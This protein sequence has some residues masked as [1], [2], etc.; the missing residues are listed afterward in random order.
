MLRTLPLCGLLLAAV[1]TQAQTLDIWTGP[2]SGGEWNTLASWSTGNPPLDS[3]TNALIGPGTNVTYSLPMG[4]TS[5]GILTNK[6]VL[7]I[8]T[9]GFNNTGIVMLNPAGTGKI[10]IGT[11]GV[12]NVSG[13]LAFCS[14]SV[15]AVSNGANLNVSGSL[16]VGCS[17]TGG[18]GTGSAGSFGILTNYGNLIAPVTSLNPGNGSVSSPCL[19][20]INGGTNNLGTV[21]IKRMGASGYGTLGAEGLVINGGVVTMTNLNAGANGAAN[22]YLTALITGGVVTNQGSVFISQGT[23]AR[24]SRVL[25]TGGLFVVPDPG[26]INPNPSASAAGTLN[27]YAVLGGTNIVGG[28]Y[29]GNSN[30]TSVGTIYFTNGAAIYVGSQGIYSNGAVTVNA[31]LNAGALFGATAPWTNAVAMKLIGGLFTFQTA[32]LDN[33]VNNIT[34]AGALS[35]AGGLN[36][37]GGGTLTLAAT[38]TYTGNTYVLGGTLAIGAT[39]GLGSPKITLA[40]GT[41]L[42]VIATGGFPLGGSQTLTGSGTVNGPVSPA[43]GATIAPGSNNVTGTLTFQGSL[44]ETGGVNNLFYLSSNP[45]GANNDFISAPGGLAL[46]GTNTITIVGSLANSGIYPLIDYGSSLTGDLTNLVV[47][48]PTGV[49]SNSATAHTIYF[50]PQ[51]SIRNATN[52]VWV[53]NPSANNWDTLGS[54]NWLNQGALDFFVAGDSVLFND[55]GTTNSIVNLPGTVTPGTI[56]INTSSNY[57]FTGSGA[58]SGTGS[59]TVSNGTL[60]VLTTNTYTGPTTFAGGVLATPILADSGAASGIGAASSDPASLIFNG[61]TFN[62]FGAS[63]GTDHGFTLTNLGGTIDVTNGTTLTLNG[64]LTGNGSLTK[65]DNGSLTLSAG[66]SYSGNTL[67]TAGTLTLSNVT[68]AGSGAIILNGGSLVLGGAIKPANTILVTNNS[69]ISGGNTGGFTG[70]K[71]VGGSSNLLLNVTT[72]VLDLTGDMSTYSGVITFANGGGAGVRFNGSI[73]SPLATW[74]L[75]SGTMD[76]MIRTG[77]TSNNIGAL[78]GGNNTTLSGR[79][80]SNNNG[81]T[82]YYIGANGLSTTFDGIVQ[83]GS[84]GTS[85][86]TAINKVGSGTLALSGVSTHTGTT[87]IGSGILALVY[88]P[89]NSSDGSIN[90]SATIN[91]VSGAV[92]D[93]SGRSDATFP[94]GSS[95][96]QLLEGRGTI[97]GSLNVGGSGMVS[98]GGGTGGSTGI[99]T[100]TNAITLNGTAWMKLNRT[101]GTTSDRLAAST[102]TYGGTLVITNIGSPLQVG[103]TFTLFSGSSLNTGSFGT[104]V[105]PNYYGIDTSSLTVNGTITVTNAFRPAISTV[106]FS[107]L[108]SGTITLTLT[109]GVASGAVNILTSTNLS[110]GWTTNT[111]TTFD[112]NGNLNSYSLTVSNDLPQLF[113]ELQVY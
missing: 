56:T 87:T 74:D 36:L 64:I 34:L 23:S 25:Q 31:A 37:T 49:L 26:V 28:F 44:T 33:T 102:I 111:A 60:T 20:Q 100:V 65:I 45:A 97:R 10:Y 1:A 89:T 75:G 53:G 94:V 106:D 66:N 90:N 110:S 105:L 86:T 95:A 39:G 24:G 101:A 84:G 73:G 52:I 55:L 67:L 92:L 54:T 46:S 76:L 9:N 107:T 69:Q 72:G 41:T 16:L 57:T 17:P 51:S 48:G 6:G 96:T 68:A 79:G 80:G 63:T 113:I 18:T 71:N 83:N 29:L 70:I 85:S 19:L 27:V 98:P 103:D 40:S 112:G 77:S 15:V 4:A 47:S 58:V 62:Y 13:N 42:D 109:N 5:F 108:S 59:L 14:N 7:N 22:S 82:T 50:T 88:N 91:L 8:L 30:N 11:N 35:G 12:L 38:N 104:I 2:A 81:A 99:L 78:Q 3:T 32:D 21:S 43:S 61:G 93:V